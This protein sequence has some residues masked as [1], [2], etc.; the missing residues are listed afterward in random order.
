ML[1]A[2]PPVRAEALR[3]YALLC[4]RERSYKDAAIAWRQLV[5]LRTCPP[6]MLRE[7]AEALAVHH[8]HRLRDPRT[9]RAFAMQSLPLQGTLTRKQALQHRLTRLDR[10][11]DAARASAPLF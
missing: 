6:Q 9:A 4:R 1:P 2:E 5:E 8:E 11:L 3:A 10:K 7:A